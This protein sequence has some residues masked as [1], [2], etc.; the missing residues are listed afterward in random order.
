MLNVWM[1]GWMEVC[2]HFYDELIMARC[3]TAR[4]YSLHCTNTNTKQSNAPTPSTIRLLTC[5]APDSIGQRKLKRVIP[6]V[7][8]LLH[9]HFGAN[10]YYY[11]LFAFPAQAFLYSHLPNPRL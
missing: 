7:Y 9:G 1:D 6:R 11:Y 3:Q 5:R 2:K 8:R 10:E 4:G